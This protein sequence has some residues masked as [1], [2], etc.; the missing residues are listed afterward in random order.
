MLIS[1]YYSCRYLPIANI[2]TMIVGIKH[3]SSA[4]FV[5]MMIIIKS[6]T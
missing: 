2:T 6:V 3:N 4:K 5:L 1:I